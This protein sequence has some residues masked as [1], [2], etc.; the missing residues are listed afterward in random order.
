MATAVNM[1][2]TGIRVKPIRELP[3]VIGLRKGLSP[4]QVARQLG[5]PEGS[6]PSFGVSRYS[7]DREKL[8]FALGEIPARAFIGSVAANEQGVL[9]PLEVDKV[10]EH[11]RALEKDQ[12]CENRHELI[13]QLSYD[14]D[15]LK[16]IQ[17][18]I[19]LTQKRFPYESG[20]VFDRPYDVGAT[21]ASRVF[22]YSYVAKRM[23]EER[24]FDIKGTVLDGQLRKEH[25]A[26]SLTLRPEGV[27]P[28]ED[29]HI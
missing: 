25:L 28:D 11:L 20:D 12:D 17:N 8:S 24:G 4:A 3:I 1:L 18:V 19:D 10:V 2:V 9:H 21:I 7:I 16:H 26:H 15:P 22:S 6:L 5:V 29:P 27:W 13:Y 14:D 23:G